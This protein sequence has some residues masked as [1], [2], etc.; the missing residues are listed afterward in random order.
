MQKNDKKSGIKDNHC[1]VFS[2]PCR[3]L[4]RLP[5]YPLCRSEPFSGI[6]LGRSSVVEKRF[7]ENEIRFLSS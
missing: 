1:V 5:R 7:C 2:S 4:R 6:A 3:I